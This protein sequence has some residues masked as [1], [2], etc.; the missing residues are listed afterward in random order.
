MKSF[1][2]F[3]ASSVR[4]INH[5]SIEEFCQ[6]YNRWPEI[7]QVAKDF[8]AINRGNS[9]DEQRLTLVRVVFTI[10]KIR[11][12]LSPIMN[13][14]IDDLTQFVKDKFSHEYKRNYAFWQSI[15]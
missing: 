6:S 10:V 5:P 3:F 11:D 13:V 9:Y 14:N 7:K 4:K 2:C 8:Y 1:I 12:M 15:S